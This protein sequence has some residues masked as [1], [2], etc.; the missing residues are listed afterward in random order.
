MSVAA[1]RPRE[2][3]QPAAEAFPLVIGLVRLD[4]AVERK[5]PPVVPM[6]VR[7]CGH[8]WGGDGRGHQT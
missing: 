2:R 8:L 7:L 4:P 1:R 6:S 5:P 3:E